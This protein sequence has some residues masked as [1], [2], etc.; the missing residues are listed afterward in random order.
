MSDKPA[1]QPAAMPAPD[2]AG[3]G[4][5]NASDVANLRRAADLH[6]SE[7]QTWRDGYCVKQKGVWVWPPTDDK[8]ALE[9]ETRVLRL[10]NSARFLRAIADKVQQPT[11][12]VGDEGG[13]G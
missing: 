6:D 5:L 8:F 12:G 3:A 2:T 11:P 9:I 1:P 4:K 13:E 7:A 10:E